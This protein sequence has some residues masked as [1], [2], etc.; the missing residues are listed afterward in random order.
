MSRARKV[1]LA[2]AAV[3]VIASVLALMWIYVTHQLWLA[4][5][6]T[7]VVGVC[8]EVMRRTADAA[9]STPAEALD[10]LQPGR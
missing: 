8:A 10:E 2:T 9:W 5:A 4:L 3:T 6:A 7:A 1:Y